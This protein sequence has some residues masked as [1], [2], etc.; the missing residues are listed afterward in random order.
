[1]YNKTDDER[2]ECMW[3]KERDN[4]T[5]FCRLCPDHNICVGLSLKHLSRKL[6]ERR[7]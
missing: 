7:N 4:E 6:K 5:I 1:M 2:L 3:R